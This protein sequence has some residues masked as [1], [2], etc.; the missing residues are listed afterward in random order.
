MNTQSSFYVLAVLAAFFISCAAPKQAQLPGESDQK[1]SLF[2]TMDTMMVLPDDEDYGFFEEPIYKGTETRHWDLIHTKLDLSFD[3]KEEKVIGTAILT[4]SPIFYSQSSLTLDAIN[5]K[6]KQISVDENVIQTYQNTDQKLIIPLNR[7]YKKGEELVIEVDYEVQPR[8]TALA[9]D[10][11]ITSNKGLFF[12]DPQDTIPGL[13]QQI[14]TQGETQYSS[15]WFPTMDMPNERG[16]QEIIL[17]VSDTMMTLSNGLL[18][19]SAPV[20]GGMRRDHWKLDLPHAPYLTM[21]AIGQWD[22][23]TDYWRG[24][25]VDYYVDPGFGPSARAIFQ[26]T[27]EMLEFFSQILGYDFVWPKYAQ[28]IVK[29]FVTGAME[30]TTAVIYG[31]FVQFNKDDVIDEGVNDYIVAHELFHQWFGDLV[32]CESWSNITLNEGFANYGEYLWQEHKFGKEQADLTRINEL[33]GYYNQAEYEVHPLIDFYYS[34]QQDMFDAHSYNKGGLVLHMLRHIVGDDAFFA[35]LQLYL[36]QNAYSAVEVSDLKKAFEEITGQDLNWFFDQWYFG[37]GHPIL[38]IS[39]AYDVDGKQLN[40]NIEQ[41]QD[42]QEFNE[43]FILPIEVA[44]IYA[45]GKMVV[46]KIKLDQKTQEFTIDVASSPVAVIIDPNDILLAVVDHHMPAS[47]YPIRVLAPISINHRL[48]A[49]RMMEEI[50]LDLVNQ[51][52]EDSSHTMQLM[53]INEL[54]ERGEVDRLYTI[55]KSASRADVQY[56]IMEVLREADP[57]RARDVAVRLLERTDKVPMIYSSLLAIAEVDIDEAMHWLT[58]FERNQSEALFVVRA[59]IAARQADGIS[60]DYFL[61]KRAANISDDYLEEFIG[62][63]AFFLSAQPKAVQDEGLNTIDSQF[64]LNTNE[65]EYRRFF[66][67]TGLLQQ[68]VQEED[69]VFQENILKTI[70]SLYQKETSDYLKSI[71]KEGLGDL[72]E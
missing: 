18:I 51:L 47:E 10:G 46:E 41:V 19:S 70:N 25:S 37:I 49:F 7:E 16:T 3:W 6:I 12:I 30:N 50:D 27:P 57:M 15:Q 11:A 67:I 68:F 20:P 5:F 13:A 66:L 32:T 24:R 34:E 56:Y 8:A 71:L 62:S 9:V 36:K 33:S 26:H 65:P 55:A 38:N 2:I 1:D 59:S 35:S 48:S 45:D 14:W 31:D 40:I 43:T 60:L 4:L 54:V 42:E 69:L 22:K 17:T 63:M 28:V 64:F 53:A 44:I 23:E 61:S 21:V 52:L 72:L 29:Q 58:H 39:H